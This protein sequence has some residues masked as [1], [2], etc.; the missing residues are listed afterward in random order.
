MY[1]NEKL[2]VQAQTNPRNLT[3]DPTFARFSRKDPRKN[4]ESCLLFKKEKKQKAIHGTPRHVGFPSLGEVAPKESAGPRLPDATPRRDPPTRRPDAT[5]RRDST[6]RAAELEGA[7]ADSKVMGNSQRDWLYFSRM[8]G[9]RLA[10][11]NKK[12]TRALGG[13]RGGG[14]G[15][16]K[17]EGGWPDQIK[18][19]VP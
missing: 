19:H 6:S 14:E 9:A 1:K 3:A 12:R 17:T 11:G 4:A 5:P 18:E 8:P 15:K 16:K 7:L 13:T 10:D 2:Q